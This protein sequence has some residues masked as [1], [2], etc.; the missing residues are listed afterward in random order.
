MDDIASAV[1]RLRKLQ[2]KPLF[3]I[4]EHDGDVRTVGKTG[5]ALPWGVFDDIRTVI[6]A[7]LAEHPADWDFTGKQE[8]E[9][10]ETC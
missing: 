9:L 4:R 5:V 10:D 3:T 6:R 7:Y 8:N 2:D 1:A